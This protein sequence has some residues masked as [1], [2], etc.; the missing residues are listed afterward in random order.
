[1]T[2]QRSKKIIRKLNIIIEEEEET[3]EIEM[4]EKEE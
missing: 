4:K 2:I 3:K 1:M